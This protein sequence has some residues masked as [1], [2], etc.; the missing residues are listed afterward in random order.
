MYP[1]PCGVSG[2]GGATEYG[3]TDAGGADTQPQS[4]RLPGQP[5]SPSAAR[6]SDASAESEIH[7]RIAAAP[8]KPT[9]GG[10]ARDWKRQAYDDPGAVAVADTG[11]LSPRLPGLEASSAEPT[12]QRR[13]LTRRDSFFTVIC[14]CVFCGDGR[15]AMANEDTPA[16][17]LTS[18]SEDDV[19]VNVASPGRERRDTV[20]GPV[21]YKPF[22]KMTAREKS[23][24]ARRAMRHP[25]MRL[26]VAFFITWLNFLIYAE[27]PVADSEGPASL[28]ILGRSASLI[29]AQWPRPYAG[30]VFAKIVCLLCALLLGPVF[31][32]QIIHKKLLSP[33]YDMF[34]E[35]KGTFMIM[36]LTTIMFLFGWA[37]VYNGIVGGVLDDKEELDKFLLNDFLGIWNQS[38]M[39]GAATGTWLG[40]SVTFFMVL[41]MIMQDQ[42]SFLHWGPKARKF[43]REGWKGRFRMVCF[44]GCMIG[45]TAIVVSVIFSGALKWDDMTGNWDLRT[46]ELGRAVLAGIIT[47]MDLT[48]VMQDWE[49]PLFETAQEVMLPGLNFENID[50]TFLGSCGECFRQPFFHIYV[51]GKWFNYGIIMM[52]MLLDMNMLKNQVVYVP[53][54]FFQ[55][56]DP[57]G[58]VWT[59]TNQTVIHDR[60]ITARS[61]A[62]RLEAGQVGDFRL[63]ARYVGHS[64]AVKALSLIPVAVGFG[65]FFYLMREERRE[66]KMAKRNMQKTVAVAVAA[67]LAHKAHAHTAAR[68]GGA[69]NRGSAAVAPSSS[70]SQGTPTEA[71]ESA[72]AGAAAGKG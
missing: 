54:D 6:E 56:T 16:G 23:R 10:D 15:R 4:F 50:F 42:R 55:Y 68:A 71:K 7:P 67:H 48:I 17:T 44:W 27:D 40:D 53:E 33:R 52:V 1:P 37:T 38:F 46:T 63:N 47:A 43:W 39:R 69:G 3:T 5:R 62:A 29:F 51:N 31:G 41:D 59:I 22:L 49:F 30:L 60:N 12:K 18:R 35:D 13:L 57:E 2:A 21:L 45:L 64:Y 36:F 8:Q 11:S 19:N 70:E 14:R 34:S 24:A 32:R 9:N 28:P 58:H 65:L 66:H 20:A 61:Y 25:N 72:S 26:F